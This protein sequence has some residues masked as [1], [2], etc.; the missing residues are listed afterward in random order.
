MKTKRLRLVHLIS[1]M[2]ALI[3]QDII[4]GPRPLDEDTK[5][6]FSAEFGLVCLIIMLIICAIGYFKLTDRDEGCGCLLLLILSG[7][8]LGF[9]VL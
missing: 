2:A 1:L 7:V 3:P 9:L 8:I 4:A 6:I 5:P